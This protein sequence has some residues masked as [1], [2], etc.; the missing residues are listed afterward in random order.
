[1]G[2]VMLEGVAL[3]AGVAAAVGAVGAFAVF[4][5]ARRRAAVAAVLAPLVVVV[6]V[7]AGVYASVRAMFLSDEDS[8]TVLLLLAAAIPVALGVGMVL[9]VRIWRIAAEAAAITA[10]RE[11]DREIEAGRREMVAWVS[12]DLRT[13]LAAVRV[14][15]EALEDGVGDDAETVRRIQAENRRMSGMVDDLLALSR[16]QSPALVLRAQL[17]DLRD[18]VSD[19]VAAVRPLADAGDVR[20]VEADGAGVLAVVDAR[21]V[22]RAVANL[23]VNAVRHT[24]RG[25]TVTVT[26]HPAP[27]D[28]AQAGQRFA[29][30]AVQDE[31]GGIPEADLSR[32]FDPGWRGTRARTPERAA[33]GVVGGQ[34]GSRESGGAG[35]GLAIV[36][37]VADVHGG[38]ATIRN[39]GAG[40]VA[41]LC[42][43]AG[44]EPRTGT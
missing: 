4:A 10:A 24:P 32:V 26:A 15:A 34:D 27:D 12:H 39:A 35:L 17:V 40:C 36:R 13:P 41:E 6:S 19:A 3:S 14:L 25:G 21:E 11:R 42:L 22:A 31:C 23:L 37:G 38:S 44:G 18:L 28:P 33:G 9:A 2:D 5:L 7:A 20:V 8:T 29:V 43:P 30:V 1:M 16:L